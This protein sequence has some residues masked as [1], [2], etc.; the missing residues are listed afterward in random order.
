MIHLD[1]GAYFAYESAGEFHSDGNWIHPT[2]TIGSFELI[3]VLE[4]TV[5]I[6]ENDRL[7]CLEPGE[8]LVLQPQLEHGGTRAIETPVAFYWYHFLTNLPVTAKHCRIADQY[9]LK[10][11]LKRLLHITNTPGY[12]PQ[13]ADA[14]GYLIFE[15]LQRRSR[16]DSETGTTLLKQ[17]QEY[18]RINSHRNLTVR[19]VAAHFGYNPDY[20]GKLF[21]KH[22]HTGFKDYLTAQRLKRIKELLLTTDKTVK[23]VAIEL[24]YEQENLLTKFFLYHEHISPTDFRNQYYNTH[25]NNH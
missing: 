6:R 23:Q 7:Y 14:V 20:M 19:T 24:G 5:H 18:I 9:E 8:I 25:M 4:G 11:L 21:R 17:I 15:E 22:F 2:R 10:Q 16:E 3:L 12:T 1:S 13:E